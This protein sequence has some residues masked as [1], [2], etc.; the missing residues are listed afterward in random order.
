MLAHQL[1]FP[2]PIEVTLWTLELGKA[3]ERVRLPSRPRLRFLRNRA[4]AWASP[5]YSVLT[6]RVVPYTLASDL[7]G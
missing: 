1:G 2:L 5:Q 3:V 7:D 4:R 6:V